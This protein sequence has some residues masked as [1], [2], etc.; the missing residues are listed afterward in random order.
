M[1]TPET[2]NGTERRQRRIRLVWHAHTA[3][4]KRGEAHP[5]R[6]TPIPRELGR[7]DLGTAA[8][9]VD[10]IGVEAPLRRGENSPTYCGI[11]R[12]F[13]AAVG[14]A[15]AASRRLILRRALRRPVEMG[16]P[17]LSLRQVAS[18]LRS[19]DYGS[20]LP[21]LAARSSRKS[22][23]SVSTEADT[24]ISTGRL[25]AFGGRGDRSGRVRPSSTHRPAWWAEVPRPPR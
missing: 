15:S 22:L 4:S 10:R 8:K 17:I 24:R 18:S 25:T 23:A 1:H 12:I 20:R 6:T 11:S 7:A 19:S 13:D 5:E 9:E 14:D 21:V 16:L 2:K 3:R